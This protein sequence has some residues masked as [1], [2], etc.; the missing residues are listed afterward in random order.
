MKKR[1]SNYSGPSPSHFK[2]VVSLSP[3]AMHSLDSLEGEGAP[4]NLSYHEST[5]PTP[6]ISSEE[7]G[8]DL[9][10][11]P[12]AGSMNTTHDAVSDTL[13][14]HSND[15]TSVYQEA[16][17]PS[18]SPKTG[19]RNTPTASGSAAISTPLMTNVRS[20]KGKQIPHKGGVI[21]SKRRR[22][23][24]R[25][26]ADMEDSSATTPT[27]ARWRIWC[28]RDRR[29]RQNIQ[30]CMNFVARLLLWCT[31]L[32]SVA[33]VVW[34]SYELKNN[35]YVS[36]AVSCHVGL[37]RQAITHSDKILHCAALITGKT[38]T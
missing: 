6:H 29:V 8:I 36:F 5:S 31:V 24:R 22:R 11:S 9:L 28:C 3:S 2:G 4:N 12:N 7:D 1:L 17:I 10:S 15:K 14:N 20:R 30:T 26:T 25:H 19:L 21:H 32:A 37:K 27:A 23:K 13:L 35:G 38:L 34:Y 33:L 16:L 18:A